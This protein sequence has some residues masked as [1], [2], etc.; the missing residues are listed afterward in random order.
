LRLFPHL[1]VRDNL[2]FGARLAGEEAPGA[3]AAAP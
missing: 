3:A 1:N 2:L